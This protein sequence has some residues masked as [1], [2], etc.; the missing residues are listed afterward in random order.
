V[1]PRKNRSSASSSCCDSPFPWTLA[2]PSFVWPARVGENCRRLE[3]LV[4]EVAVTLFEIQSCLAYTEEDL[5]RGMAS[6]D[7]SY[8]LHLPL[9]L[10]WD[11]PARAAA[12]AAR[13]VEMTAFVHPRAFVLHPPTSP[14]ALDRF[15]QAWEQLGFK[16]STL[17]LENIQGNDLQA[18]WPVIQESD[19]G[20]CLDLGHLLLYDQETILNQEAWLERLKMLHVYGVYQKSSRHGPLSELS[21][22]GQ[23]MLRELL[24]AL[25]ANGVVVLEVFS[26]GDL[27]TSLDIF[28]TWI[29]NWT[30]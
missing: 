2:A 1:W 4:D 13:L 6:L 18:I 29:R 8:H 14:H 25:P 17:L 30:L 11:D 16:V 26:A 19:C 28:K 5:P 22:N 20:L 9:D 7:L 24:R 15:F 12:L 21:S 27:F 10:P 23:G 3:P